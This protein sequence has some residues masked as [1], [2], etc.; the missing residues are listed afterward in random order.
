MLNLFS[1]EA[2]QL[3]SGTVNR[4]GPTMKDGNTWLIFMLT[5]DERVFYIK[6]ENQ[7][8]LTAKGDKV[9]FKYNQQYNEI[10]VDVETFKNNSIK[11]TKEFKKAKESLIF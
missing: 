3:V 1:K 8:G 4:I 2:R 5:T 7:I 11:S 10:I 6:A 9:S